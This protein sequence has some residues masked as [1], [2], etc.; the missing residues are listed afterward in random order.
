VFLS[1]TDVELFLSVGICAVFE[2][3]WV[4]QKILSNESKPSFEPWLKKTQQAQLNMAVTNYA[5]NNIIRKC[6][7]YLGNYCY[8]N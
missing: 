4:R 2:P 8:Y 1:K 7:F 6:Y 5:A 3:E